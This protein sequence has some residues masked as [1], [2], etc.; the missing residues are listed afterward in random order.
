MKLRV[1]TAGESHGRCLTAVVEGMPSGV[2]LDDGGINHDLARRQLGYGRG[3]RMKIE[4]DRAEITSGVRHGLTLGSPI[5]L[6]IQNRDWE[7]WMDIMSADVIDRSG[8]Q[9]DAKQAIVSRPR[10]GHADLAGGLKY[11]HRDMRNILERSSARETAARVAA[12]AVAKALLEEFGINVMSWVIGIGPVQWDGGAI[13]ITNSGGD[14]DELFK[15]AEASPVR[16][17]DKA[18]T[19]KM[20][21]AID[22]A[23]GS[24]DSLGGIFETVVTG[25]PPGIGSHVQW[26]RKLNARLAEA[27]MSIQ[28]I[29]GCEVGL[30]FEAG[31]RPGSNVHDE[32]FYKRGSTKE[33]A[34]WPQ[35]PRFYRK[36]NNAGGIEGGMSNGEPIILRAVMKP[37]PTL[38]KPLVSVDINTKR[39]FKASVERSDVCA[40]P[41]ASVVAEAVVAL[42]IADAFLEKFGGDS[43]IEIERNYRGYLKQVR[44][45]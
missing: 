19:A 5:A 17:P 27:L 18:A 36:T 37:I 16:C 24:G 12:G 33:A 10:P 7:N 40:V 29:K 2:P 23:R 9:R 1:I 32:I 8:W 31:R 38:Y 28:A 39:P 6:L 11:N 14:F 26:D 42:A 45:F 15:K 3:G 43:K 13:S 35:L 21:K 34:F 4:K 30:G 20:K 41:A 25:V 22:A 44:E